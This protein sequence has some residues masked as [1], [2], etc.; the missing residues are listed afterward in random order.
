MGDRPFTLQVAQL[1]S[2]AAM[3]LPSMKSAMKSAMKAK[4]MKE[5]RVS[6]VAKGRFAKALV[7]KGTKEKT[8]G[9]LKSDDLM[10][11]KRGKVVSKR[12]NALGKRRY[13][14]V[15]DW[16]ESVMEAREAL[17]VKGFLAINGKSLQGKALYVKARSLRATKRSVSLHVPF[18]SQVQTLPVQTVSL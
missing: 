17:H 10:T 13:H 7:L 18:L 2:F 12:A 11:N 1:L 4:S 3:A 15:E 8:V 9:G 5:K 14:Q 16:V 6:K